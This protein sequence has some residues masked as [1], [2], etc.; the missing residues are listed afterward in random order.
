MKYALGQRLCGGIAVALAVC[1][2]LAMVRSFRPAV[3]WYGEIVPAGVRKGTVPREYLHDKDQAVMVYV[4]AGVFI[5]GTSAGQAH[6]L[7]AQFG[8]YFAVETPQRSIDLD[9][10]YMDKF[11]VTNHQYAQFLAVFASAGCEFYHLMRLDKQ[12][13]DWHNKKCNS[14]Y[15]TQDISK[16]ACQAAGN[17]VALIRVKI[18]PVATNNVASRIFQCEKC[19]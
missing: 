9:A 8:A 12:T 2:G 10:Y 14:L 3:G 5:R 11:E 16:G 1:V 6:A 4:P 19:L 15:V 7:A 18:N 13:C 17:A